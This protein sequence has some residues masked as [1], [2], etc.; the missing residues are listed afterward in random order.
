MKAKN[1]IFL[2]AG[3]LFSQL[4][5]AQ[6]E[7][8]SDLKAFKPAESNQ[9]G[10]LFPQVN[11]EGKVRASLYAPHAS[12]VLLDLG[13]KKYEM[14][15]N[16]AGLW[17]GE[18]EPQ[19]EGFHYYQ[20][21][22]DG[23][24]IPDPNSRYFYG[25][26]RLGSGIEV[27]ADDEAFYALQNVPHGMVSENIY[28]SDLT[29]TWRRC[30]IYT[31]ASYYENNKSRFP[32]LYLQH[33]SFE[34]ETGWVNQGK[35]NIILDNLIAQN[36]AKPMIIVTDN[37]YAFKPGNNETAQKGQGISIFEDVL[38]KEVIPM[39]D[40]RFRTLAD[41]EHRAIAGLSMGANQTMR[42]VMRNLDKF[43]YYGG[44]SGTSN[45]PNTDVIDPNVFMEGRFKTGTEVNKRLKLFWLG[46]GTKEPAPFPKSVGAFKSMLDQQ[47]IKY[48]Y[49]ESPKTAHEWL[50]WRRSLQNFAPLL[51]R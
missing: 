24:A 36:Q 26:G 12:K 19:D 29:K 8:K 39:I 27:P 2:F 48:T 32:V 41:R 45:Y 18:S 15:K 13:G 7:L 11:D 37:G 23:A 43:A 49:Y 35:A 30:F 28:Y 38:I 51:F 10:K 31:P 40:K 33:G 46:L 6:T 34:D 20:L 44:F 4:C 42:I 25:A 5:L 50:T 47:G 21:N 1:V 16:E 14:V 3:C 9:P 22:V 17:T